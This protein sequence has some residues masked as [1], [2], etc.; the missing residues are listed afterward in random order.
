MVHRRGHQSDKRRGKEKN[1]S[2]PFLSEGSQGL[3]QPETAWLE[4]KTSTSKTNRHLLIESLPA[5]LEDEFCERLIQQKYSSQ[6]LSPD[7]TE[8][9]IKTP[10][11]E[12]CMLQFE[13][14]EKADY[15]LPVGVM[16]P[17]RYPSIIS[18]LAL[19]ANTTRFRA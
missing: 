14:L 15:A 12:I 5:I 2:N 16:F 9:Q 8:G 1:L 6:I 13:D 17:D 18:S 7:A 19:Y 10:R 11:L 4:T 3:S